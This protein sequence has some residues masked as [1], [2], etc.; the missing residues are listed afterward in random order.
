[1]SLFGL[2]R[3]PPNVA[4]LKEKR[5]IP[6]LVAALDNKDSA[7]ATEAE[8]ALITLYEQSDDDFVMQLIFAGAPESR[9]K[10]VGRIL[11]RIE[12]KDPVAAA[13]S[14]LSYVERIN[15]MGRKRGI[16]YGINSWYANIL[17]KFGE[18]AIR[19]A[20]FFLNSPDVGD[21]ASHLL[22][23]IGEPAYDLA[24]QLL[25]AENDQLERKCRTICEVEMRIE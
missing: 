5:A 24:L 19:P 2:L 15:R 20:I 1:M 25:L 7:I 16:G 13:T 10:R 22:E 14:T 3:R 6:K 12:V 23:K 21:I 8:K 18:D 17:R 11:K 9:R 4:R